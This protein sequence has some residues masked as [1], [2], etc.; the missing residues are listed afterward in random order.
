MDDLKRLVRLFREMEESCGDME[1]R[2]IM[3]SAVA[4]VFLWIAGVV[5][6]WW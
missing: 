4:L 1:D 2:V 5:L 6:H 3:A